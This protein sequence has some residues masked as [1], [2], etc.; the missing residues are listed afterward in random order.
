MVLSTKENDVQWGFRRSEVWDGVADE[1]N[2]GS[3]RAL[4]GEFGDTDVQVEQRLDVSV[5]V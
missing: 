2:V 5:L 3:D 4:S 1:S